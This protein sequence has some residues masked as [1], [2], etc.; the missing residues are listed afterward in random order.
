MKYLRK[1]TSYDSLMNIA[2]G[3][4][5]ET[6]YLI[7]RNMYTQ[8]LREWINVYLHVCFL[9]HETRRTESTCKDRL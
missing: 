9:T 8:I 1:R 7:G 5:H 4:I 2:L 3:P 6:V